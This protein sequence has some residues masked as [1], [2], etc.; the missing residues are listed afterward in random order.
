MQ[1]TQ[2]IPASINLGYSDTT[3]VDTFERF[4]IRPIEA[5]NDLVE[6]TFG[7]LSNSKLII[8]EMEIPHLC[9]GATSIINYLNILNPV[10]RV[11]ERC[12]KSL[13]ECSSTTEGSTYFVL[14][15]A[16]LLKSSLKLLKEGVPKDKIMHFTK[17]FL[18]HAKKTTEESANSLSELT[19]EQQFKIIKGVFENAIKT[20]LSY[21]RV[22]YLDLFFP[23]DINYTSSSETLKSL[24]ES[25]TPGSKET[26]IKCFHE[27]LKQGNIN[28]ENFTIIQKTGFPVTDSF[29]I[30]GI[31]LEE[32][33]VLPLTP[34]V[35]KT[36]FYTCN[37]ELSSTE[38]KGV[39]LLESAE[40]LLN[41]NQ[42]EVSLLKSK[43][44]DI[45]D[46]GVEVMITTGNTAPEVM[47]LFNANGIN[48][49]MVSSK[50]NMRKLVKIA[51]G[52]INTLFE[53][54]KVIKEL[55]IEKM[56]WDKLNEYENGERAHFTVFSVPTTKYFSLVLFSPIDYL[57]E[58]TN[59]V[60]M[61]AIG[62]VNNVV[63]TKQF[64]YGGGALES[65]IIAKS[66]NLKVNYEGKESTVYKQLV[67][68]VERMLDKIVKNGRQPDLKK[69]L[70]EGEGELSVDIV[71][72]IIGENGSV[73]SVIDSLE[74]KLKLFDM[75][76]EIIDT[77]LCVDN[78]YFAK[79]SGGPDFMNG[80]PG[81]VDEDKDM[82]F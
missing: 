7:P 63:Q 27:H 46:S 57:G 51:R 79:L 48:V 71:E 39:I 59:D 58:K 64:I 47:E 78:I 76:E 5:L 50:Y 32:T 42:T 56:C 72:N 6:T 62:S 12:L 10:C 60:L 30:H 67:D 36:A 13:K 21:R 65:K 23:T 52:E 29:L 55:R 22:F 2:G 14:F 53:A 20:K 75:A 82:N 38:S 54:P 33:P 66:K 43:V 4:C 77:T 18:R 80:R 49:V 24:E 74:P 1:A 25:L 17:A 35:Y 40:E 37:F 41:Y 34:R 45:K 9:S 19:G 26:T 31:V 3:S 44:K 28:T 70:I 11:V 61:S 73:V 15:V 69:L 68:A 8:N 81:N 16:E